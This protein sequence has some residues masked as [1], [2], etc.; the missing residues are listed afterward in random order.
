MP[1]LFPS[2]I[3]STLGRENEDDILRAVIHKLPRRRCLKSMIYDLSRDEKV[4]RLRQTPSAPSLAR[5][6]C[7]LA[8]RKKVRKIRSAVLLH[9]VSV[10]L[11]LQDMSLSN[12]YNTLL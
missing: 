2:F 1:K 12:L 7:C 11:V 10:P 6:L 5:R 8:R 3:R 9:K 4:G